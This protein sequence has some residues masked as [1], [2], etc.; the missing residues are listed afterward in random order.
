MSKLI[1]AV[2]ALGALAL[3]L[4]A[5]GLMGVTIWRLLADSQSGE[6]IEDALLGAV[7]YL[8]VAIAVFD[9]AKYIVEE[10]VFSDDE[11]RNAAETRRSL[12]KFGS[13]IVIAVLLEGLVLAFEVARDDVVDLVWPILLM[14]SGTVLFI[15]IAVFQR[16][17]ASTE[18]MVH[19]RDPEVTLA[20]GK[21][22]R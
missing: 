19:E 12:T 8:I 21:S 2:F 1:K 18:R 22:S 14:L 10:E 20:R 6:P 7:G 4:I 9:V 13:T 16:L 5:V 3:M 11:R 17:S 15:A